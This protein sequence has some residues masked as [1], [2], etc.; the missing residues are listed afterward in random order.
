M[1]EMEVAVSAA[2]TKATEVEEPAV[3]LF[4]TGVL[5]LIQRVAWGNSCSGRLEQV[6]FR[7]C[8]F[9]IRFASGRKLSC[10]L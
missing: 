9:S 3:V 6:V 7:R 10:G 2:A 1:V 5:M 8:G 4:M